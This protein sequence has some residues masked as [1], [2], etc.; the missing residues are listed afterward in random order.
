MNNIIIA[1]VIL[2]M[3]GI[4]CMTMHDMCDAR[5]HMPGRSHVFMIKGNKLFAQ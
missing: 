2:K 4:L 5:L 1:C 3:H